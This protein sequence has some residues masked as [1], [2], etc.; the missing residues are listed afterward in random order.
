[1]QYHETL[2]YSFRFHKKSALAGNAS[3]ARCG[4]QTQAQEQNPQ[5][6]AVRRSLQ[7]LAK[8]LTV[9]VYGHPA[10]KN[11][12]YSMAG[13]SSQHEFVKWRS[14]TNC[15]GFALFPRPLDSKSEVERWRPV[16]RDPHGCKELQNHMLSSRSQ[17]DLGGLRALYFA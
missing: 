10:V 11:P 15:S 3:L 14:L 2:I 12:S 4:N 17:A 5:C 1:M 9:S 8:F 6:L 7:C 16:F 13:P